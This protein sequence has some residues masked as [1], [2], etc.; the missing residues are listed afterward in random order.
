MPYALSFRRQTFV[1][2]CVAACLSMS[3]VL[4]AQTEGTITVVGTGSSSAAAERASLELTVSSQDATATGLFVKAADVVLN[5]KKKLVAAGVK[6][7]DIHEKP[8]RLMPNYE[9]GQNGQ[10]VTG[11]RMDTPL[12]VEIED[13]SLIPHLIDLSTASGAGSVSL[14]E[15]TSATTSEMHGQASKAAIADARKRAA[16][17]AK[18]IGRSVGEVVSITDGAAEPMQAK[19]APKGEE[20]EERER[21]GRGKQPEASH[22]LS[23]SVSFKVV[24]RLK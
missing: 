18:E 7:E 8:Y 15:F 2:L 20:E 10:R 9:Y 12:E 14:G 17:I 24:F 11:Y 19:P 16:E 4:Q 23:E 21:E 13:V 5:L 22:V 3:S 6:R 1:A